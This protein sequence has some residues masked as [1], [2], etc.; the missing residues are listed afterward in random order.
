RPNSTALAV[1]F[2]DIQAGPPAP[3]IW[4]GTGTQPTSGYTFVEEGHDSSSRFFFV[5]RTSGGSGSA[6][7]AEI[8]APAYLAPLNLYS[9]PASSL[10]IVLEL[11]Q[12]VDP[13]ASNI[14]PT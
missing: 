12:P 8:Q 11:D 6:L 3:L 9:D 13:S 1:L 5:P 10:A 4:D 7:G 14:N 2:D